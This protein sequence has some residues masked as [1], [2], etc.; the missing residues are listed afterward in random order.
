MPINKDRNKICYS[1]IIEYYA[2]GKMN[3]LDL[4]ASTWINSKTWCLATQKQAVNEYVHG[5]SLYN[6][7]KQ[8]NNALYYE[9]MH[10]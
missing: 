10:M 2:A 3:K 5:E 7:L 8:L 1:P 4:H 6:I 9:Y